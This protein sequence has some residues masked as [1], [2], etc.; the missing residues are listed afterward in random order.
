MRHLSEWDSKERLGPNVPRPRERLT[1]TV[2]DALA[3][4][5]A[6]GGPVV[7]KASGVAHKSEQGL[8]RPGLDDAGLRACW[9]DLAA[10]G[11]GRVLV[12]E[13]CRGELELLVGGVR[14]PQFGPLV[15]IG[16]G[17]VAAEVDPDATFLLAPVEP[18]EVEHAVRRLRAAPLFF[19]FRGR[20]AVDLDAVEVIVGAVGALLVDDPSVVEVDCNPVLVDHGRPLVL[21]ALVVVDDDLAVHGAGQECGT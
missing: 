6:V 18:G 2:D 9:S 17:G 5:R 3:H 16:I 19:G 11:D 20:T 1:T 14:D 7:A 13:E 8:V 10:A 4:R 15:T 21:D 12:A